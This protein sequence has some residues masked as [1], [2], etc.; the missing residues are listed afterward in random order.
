MTTPT[1]D[2]HSGGHSDGNEPVAPDGPTG[3]NRP[4]PP[5]VEALAEEVRVRRTDLLERVAAAS[6]GQDVTVVAV[7]KAF[8]PEVA[9]AARLA[10][11]V[12]CGENY[13]QELAEKAIDPVVAAAGPIEWHFIGGL[14]RNKVKQLGSL[15]SLWQSIDR[16]SLVTELAKR[17]PGARMLVQVN[18]S[19]EDAKSGCDPDRTRELVDIAREAGLHAGGLMTVGPTPLAG[20][21]PDPRPSFEMLRRLG[22]QCEVADLSMG[23]S[24][25]YE[26]ALAEGATIIRVGSVLF[27]PRPIRR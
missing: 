20:E 14:Q 19:G 15:V 18:T 21:T 11:F 5:A 24:G 27:G 12:D 8:G 17:A 3:R 10:G 22:E 9:A 1:P 25:D 23:M 6:H 26:L 13:A 7:T 2:G 4:L 16:S